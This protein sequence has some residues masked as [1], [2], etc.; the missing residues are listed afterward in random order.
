MSQNNELFEELA[1]LP[2]QLRVLADSISDLANAIYLTASKVEH[3][4][5]NLKTKLL[6]ENSQDPTENPTT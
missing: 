5:D 4:L 6:T 1:L 3:R 2:T